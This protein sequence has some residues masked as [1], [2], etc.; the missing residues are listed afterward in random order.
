MIAAAI[1]NIFRMVATS[2]WDSTYG[3]VWAYARLYLV[4]TEPADKH[5]FCALGHLLGFWHFPLP[6]DENQAAKVTPRRGLA[7]WNPGGEKMAQPRG[8]GQD[9]FEAELKLRELD[10]VTFLQ[11]LEAFTLNGRVMNEYIRSAI[12]ADEAVTLSIVKPFHFSLKS[13]HLRSSLNC[14]GAAAVSVA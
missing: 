1:R 4:L 13:C 6:D 11:G 2:G 5:P 10:R 14:F 3:I 7:G 9:E 12:L 8:L